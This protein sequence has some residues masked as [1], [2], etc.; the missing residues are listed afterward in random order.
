MLIRH[1]ISALVTTFVVLSATGWAFAQVRGEVGLSNPGTFRDPGSSAFASRSYGLGG[2]QSTLTMPNSGV[3]SNSLGSSGFSIKRPGGDGGSSAGALGGLPALKGAPYRASGM[4]TPG[5]L[6]N[7]QMDNGQRAYSSGVMGGQTVLGMAGQ[8]LGDEGLNLPDSARKQE[9]IT[10]LVPSTPSHYTSML[11]DGERLFRSGEF[12]AAFNKFTLANYIGGHD[13]ESLLSMTHASFA[14]SDVSYSRPAYYLRQALRY[15]PDLPQVPLRVKEFYGQT[16]KFVEQEIRLEEHIGRFPDDA[17]ANLMMAYIRWFSDQPDG[18][19][20]AKVAL[21]RA[22]G[23]ANAPDTLEAIE[24][25][26]AGM[27]DSGKATGPLRPVRLANQPTS[28]SARQAAN[29]R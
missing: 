3:L 14:A 9:P 24:T 29:A 13:P 19:A 1:N 16:A 8:Y 27:V 6:N 25:F 20:E 17:D 26:W 28:A 2:L 5:M 12:E 11:A 21:E 4:G 7:P 23:S 15:L 22:L 10:S 18:P